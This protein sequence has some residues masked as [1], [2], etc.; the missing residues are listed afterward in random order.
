M[1]ISAR[2]SA[3]KNSK[4]VPVSVAVAV[5]DDDEHA[6]VIADGRDQSVEPGDERAVCGAG[7]GV[8]W[9]S[10]DRVSGGADEPS[11]TS[12]SEV[13]ARE[14]EYVADSTTQSGYIH[15]AA[16]AGVGYSITM[17]IDSSVLF[18]LR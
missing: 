18:C 5:G 4:D 7:N 15:F 10:P 1:G 9:L 11:N 3:K 12:Q 8:I 17:G 14:T 13:I 16:T 6:V 2:G